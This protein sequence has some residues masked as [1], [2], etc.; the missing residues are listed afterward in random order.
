MPP[1]DLEETRAP[2]PG[3]ADVRR[4]RSARRLRAVLVVTA[5][6]VVVV[7]GG[8]AVVA[9]RS[10]GGTGGTGSSAGGEGPSSERSRS[11]A[12]T[13]TPTTAPTTTAPPVPTSVPGVTVGPLVGGPGPIPVVHRVP[14]TDPVV[15]ITIDDGAFA[16][17]DALKLIGEHRI[18][19]TLFLNQSYFAANADYFRRLQDSGAVLGAHTSTHAELRGRDAAFQHAEICDMVAEF[20]DR[21]GR[22]PTLFRP[23]YGSYDATTLQQAASCGF[24][25]ALHWSA[26]ADS[27]SI[28]TADGPLRAGDIVLLHFRPGLVLRLYTVLTQIQAA[29]LRPASLSD[30]LDS[31]P[32]APPAAPA[33]GAG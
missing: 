28:V 22:A 33:T 20:R 14:T 23:P 19:V 30:Y 32:P 17:E 2:E 18:P 16:D 11:T 31:A 3:L 12:S 5:L 15:F 4:A 6:V 9:T 27:G 24:T 26:V 1:T 29:G 21:F 8:L 7:A 13:S 25:A 10:G